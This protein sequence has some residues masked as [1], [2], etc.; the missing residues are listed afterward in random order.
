M[1]NKLKVCK[2]PY[3]E[4]CAAVVKNEELR[5]PPQSEV[6]WFPGVSGPQTTSSF[7]DSL[8]L[9]GF[10][11]WSYSQLRLTTL[12]ER[13]VE[14]KSRG[15]RSQASRSPLPVK[16]QTLNFLWAPLWQHVGHGVYCGSLLQPRDF[17]GGWSRGHPPDSIYQNSRLSGRK[18][19]F[20]INHIVV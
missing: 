18:Q 14:A 11:V 8:E 15:N 20:I 6:E 16:S 3:V 13:G 9:T 5:V 12:K 19:G 4:D 7:G 2:H 17:P 1:L 10:S